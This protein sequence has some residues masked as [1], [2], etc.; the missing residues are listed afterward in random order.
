MF[1]L[2]ISFADGISQSET[3]FVRRPQALIGA[4]EY[5]HVVID[6]L[7][8][9]G[10]QFRI[11]RNIG[12]K[13]RCSV[14]GAPANARI[15]DLGRGVFQRN[16]TITAGRVTF[17]VTALDI[18]L[19]VKDGEPPDR[20]G[21]R[22]V[23]QACAVKEC[24]FPAVVV[25]GPEPIIV[26]FSPQQ[27]IYIGR[28]NKCAV[29]LDSA[30]ISS[31]HA[32]L[33]F[34]NGEF[35]IEDLGS[36]N[37][38]FVNGQQISGR[39]NVQPGVPIV[40][41]REISIVGVITEGELSRHASAE[42]KPVEKSVSRRYP[43]LISVSEVARPARVVLPL[44]TPI[45]IGRDPASDMWL[46]APHVSRKHCEV[47]LESE[48]KVVISDHSTNGTAYD[49]GILRKGQ[50]LEA[51]TTP[52]VLNFGGDLTVALCFDGVQETSF[53]A[54]QG[55]ADCFTKGEEK[56]PTTQYAPMDQA[57]RTFN[58][59]SVSAPVNTVARVGLVGKLKD[60]RLAYQLSS[61]INKLIMVAAIALVAF[62]IVVA[63]VYFWQQFSL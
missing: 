42:A 8:D 20:S 50:N 51:A 15:P 56:A 57:G 40:L 39:V 58:G 28:S 53:L 12:Q 24:A 29:R 30:D 45:S 9:L 21:V 38:T 19:M 49:G 35:W 10:Y 13:F 27:A 62:F 33:G 52:K 61:P 18:D 63:G 59:S 34:E 32:R 11:S 37:G 26:S 14:V 2:E 5:A 48:N 3:V 22:V 17:V 7:K 6:D 31:K 41:G 36:T 47:T 4:S 60:W 1:A 46:G 44:G 55:A 54:A 43:V 23:R 16:T 25:Q